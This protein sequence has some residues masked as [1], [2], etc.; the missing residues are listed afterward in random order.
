MRYRREQTFLFISVMVV[1]SWV[2]HSGLTMLV[3]NSPINTTSNNLHTVMFE[4][5]NGF[6]DTSKL[7]GND[8]CFAM[9][10]TQ[11][12]KNIYI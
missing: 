4:A 12:N 2:C 7:Q 8:T 9:Q 11:S 10:T 3:V 6:G 5:K 1:L